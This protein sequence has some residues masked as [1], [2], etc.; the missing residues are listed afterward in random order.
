MTQY[1]FIDSPNRLSQHAEKWRKVETD[2]ELLPLW[3]ADMDFEPLPEIRQVIRDYAGHHV[4]GYPYASDSLYQSIID[5]EDRQHGYKIERESILLI[6]GVVPAL[7]VAIQALTEEGDAVLINT[8]VY[9]PF[10]RTVKLNNRQLVTNSLVDVDGIF[11]LNLDQLEKDIVENQ[12]K[13]YIFCN[14]HNPGGRVWTREEVLAIG[15][16]CQKHGVILVSDEIHQDLTLYGHK[17]Y[18]FNTVAESF[19]EFSIILS[20]ATKTFNIAGTKNSFA[21]IENPS[22]RK[23]FAKRQ[24]INNQHEI[25]TIGLLTT[26]AAFTYGDEWLKELKV[27]LERNIDFVEEY[28]ATHTRIKVM[29]PQ[30]TY[31]IWLDFSAY[32][33]EHAE[34]FDILHCKAKLILNDGLTFG[35]EGKY[36]ARLNVAAPFNM[37]EEACQRLGKVFG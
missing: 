10:A 34:L 14:P 19:K 3:I 16:L 4:F 25:P 7:S 24:L 8:P 20:S 21:I 30:G 11:R 26:E 1:N 35:K 28:L 27:I 13:L 29:K 33:L 17:H 32:E 12:V 15:R 18:S 2:K 36:H 37:I 23:T 9:P 6:E 22:I 5:W 31:L